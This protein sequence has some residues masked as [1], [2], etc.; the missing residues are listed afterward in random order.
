MLSILDSYV[1]LLL[2]TTREEDVDPI[3]WESIKEI[4]EEYCSIKPTL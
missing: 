2:L 1:A 3:I 4:D